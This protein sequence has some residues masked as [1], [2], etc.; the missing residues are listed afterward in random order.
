MNVIDN[1]D[2]N[3][4]YNLNTFDHD[5]LSSIFDN[6]NDD[7]ANN[8][9]NM[10]NNVINGMNNNMNNNMN[11]MNNIMNDLDMTN[12]GRPSLGN[13]PGMNK[14]LIKHMR[15]RNNR[16]FKE[17][18]ANFWMQPQ[19]INSFKSSQTQSIQPLKNNTSNTSLSGTD[20][21][22][23]FHPIELSSSKNKYINGKPNAT[24]DLRI[25]LESRT[26]SGPVL[27]AD[28]LGI[29][30]NVFR[31]SS[32]SQRFGN[33][34]NMRSSSNMMENNMMPP[35]TQSSSN[36]NT[37]RRVSMCNSSVISDNSN[38]SQNS[39]HRVKPSASSI[40]NSAT[41]IVN[42]NEFDTVCFDNNG[43][44]NNINMDPIP[45]NHNHTDG[46]FNNSNVVSEPGPYDIVCGR[47]SGAYNY[48]GN[49]RFRVTIEMNL[50]R[51]IDSPTREDKT[52]VIKSIV[53]MLHEQVGARFLKKET[54][55]K[56][57]GSRRRGTP[58]YTIMT[59][60]QAREKVGHA[61]RD[62]V[63]TARKEQQQGK[64]QAE[65]QAPK[66]V[67]KQQNQ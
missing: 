39:H 67:P 14:L 22:G 4:Y 65:E 25:P 7:I 38:H 32:P 35:M 6:S 56:N 48:I 55:K 15:G 64:K 10:K 51:Y 36:F 28:N 37:S 49:R 12:C 41:N 21:F 59:D 61:L 66:E 13:S 57:S 62:L 19:N 20:A 11:S 30:K 16:D 26:N 52:N 29:N 47:N 5:P 45:S 43:M 34:S 1:N 27:R 17:L 58:R 18:V 3:S 9:N 31:S 54:S 23:S 8:M 63:I 24:M 44:N 53:W 2:T 50:Q 33:S 60:K 46:S 42:G 40:I